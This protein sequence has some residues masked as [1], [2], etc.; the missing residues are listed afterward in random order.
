[1]KDEGWPPQFQRRIAGQ[2]QVMP[3]EQ[4]GFVDPIYM[5]LMAL[6]GIGIAL[7][8]PLLEAWL[9]DEAITVWHWAGLGGGVALVAACVIY[10]VRMR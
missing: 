7:A 8:V 4:Q 9:K 2:R 10:F 5:I 3:R 1:M 6:T